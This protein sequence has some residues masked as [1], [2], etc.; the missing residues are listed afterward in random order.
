M[1]EPQQ[2]DIHAVPLLDGGHGNGQVPAV[3]ADGADGAALY[4]LTI[5][6]DTDPRPAPAGIALAQLG[7]AA[8]PMFNGQR[9]TTGYEALPAARRGGDRT[10]DRGA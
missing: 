8:R 7:T 10:T 6:R 1:P 9:Q 3:G 4:P 2:A 5:L